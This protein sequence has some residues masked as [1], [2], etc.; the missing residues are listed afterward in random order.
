MVGEAKLIIIA[1][2][3]HKVAIIFEVLTCNPRE[4]QG[5]CVPLHR[6]SQFTC[7]ADMIWKCIPTLVPLSET[8][9]TSQRLFGITPD[10]NITGI[11]I[12]STLLVCIIVSRYTVKVRLNSIL[13]LYWQSKATLKYK[14][15]MRPHFF[16]VPQTI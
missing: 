2:L 14:L 4:L 7:L 11:G 10:C 16:F 1:L 5:F 6:H 12:G 15:R 9:T 13:S 8:S 3:I